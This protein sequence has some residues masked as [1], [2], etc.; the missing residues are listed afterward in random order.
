MV[1]GPGGCR[2]AG[3]VGR[4]EQGGAGSSA[5]PGVEVLDGTAAY[6]YLRASGQGG[7]GAS[8]GSCKQRDSTAA[9][10]CSA[11]LPRARRMLRAL[12][13]PAGC[14]ALAVMLLIGPLA[15]SFNSRMDARAVFSTFA[16]Q[17]CGAAC[18]L[19]SQRCPGTTLLLGLD[20]F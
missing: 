11:E 8:Q 13:S 4:L 9:A 17:V 5:G 18:K 20:L 14:D 1:R 6:M 10:P 3:A 15:S 19:A 2:A 12:R 16:V 7:L